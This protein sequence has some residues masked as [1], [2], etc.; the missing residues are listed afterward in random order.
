M[1][2][3]I[4]VNEKLNIFWDILTEDEKMEVELLLE[5]SFE[6]FYETSVINTKIAPLMEI[7][8]G[9]EK[10]SEANEYFNKSGMDKLFQRKYEIVKTIYSPIREICR[11]ALKKE[12]KLMPMEVEVLL[13]ETMCFTKNSIFDIN[14]SNETKYFT[15]IPK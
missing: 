9:I 4:K 14:F 12:I 5:K 2:N 8:R 7:S 1:N 11:M 6:G 15:I 13:W 3:P 10:V